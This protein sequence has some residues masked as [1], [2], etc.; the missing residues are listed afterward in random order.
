MVRIKVVSF[1]PQRATREEWARY[2]EY[3]RTRHAETDPDDPMLADA[4]VEARERR[5]D[6]AWKELDFAV[7][8]LDGSEEWIGW[9][10]REFARPDGPSYEE[11]K[12]ILWIW[13]SLL[14]SYRQQG[15]GR[16]L[17]QEAANYAREH[18]KSLVM[19]YAE[20]ASGRAFWKAVGAQDAQHDRQSRLDLERVDWTMVEQWAAEGPVRSPGSKLAWFTNRIDD[21]ELEEWCRAFTEVWNMMPRD[22]LDLGD[23]VFTPERRRQDEA[24][25]AE[26]GG[27]LLTAVTREEDGTISGLTEM[28][29]Y[30]EQDWMIHQWMTGVRRPYR[31]RGLG[32]WIKAAMLL[33]V[34][35]EFPQVR[36]VR[37]GNAFSN[38]PMLSIN[39]RLGFKLYRE[40]M[41]VQ[42]SLEDLE[43]YLAKGPE[44]EV[45]LLGV[46]DGL[47]G[48]GTARD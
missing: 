12:H 44:S 41:E 29:Y 32:K 46:E 43:A 24:G 21:E 27:T 47:A 9:H 16:R 38:A 5:P 2:H 17:L 13:I 7:I 25:I 23:E 39:E 31:G 3:R 37:T 20:E 6:T 18:D 36:I 19:S 35:E 22:D 34:R 10:T 14:P 48:I 1:D 30:P 40:G 45:T 26:A 15:I 33:R 8:D 42:T 4:T 11:N 28:G